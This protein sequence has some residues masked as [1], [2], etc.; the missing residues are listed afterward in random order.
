MNL[1]WNLV[2]FTRGASDSFFLILFLERIKGNKTQKMPR[3]ARKGFKVV[4]DGKFFTFS[5]KKKL[6]NLAFPP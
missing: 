2:N 1:K 3:K 5:R 6:V 4:K